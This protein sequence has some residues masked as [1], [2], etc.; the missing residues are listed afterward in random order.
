MTSCGPARRQRAA[1][2]EV[3]QEHRR[4]QVARAGGADRQPGV[5]VRQAPSADTTTMSSGSSG[6]S[7]R[8]TLVTS[9][10]DGPP[11]RTGSAAS[12]SPPATVDRAREEVE[13]EVVGRDHV[14]GRHHPVAH[15]L[16]DPGPDEHAPAHVPHHRVAAVHRLGVVPLTGDRVEDDRPDVLRAL[17]AREHG[18]APVERP[19]VLDARRSPRR[20]LGRQQRTAPVAVPGVVGEVHGHHRPHLLAQ[21]LKGKN[22][23]AVAGMAVGDQGLDRQDAH[24]H[25]FTRGCRETVTPHGELAMGSGRT[26]ASL[27]KPAPS[28][29]LER[30]LRQAHPVAVDELVARRTRGRR[31]RRG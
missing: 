20:C 2:E 26:P 10:T 31:P 19:A 21:P 13:L 18:L 29:H 8:T 24:G 22:G 16:G 5:R 14:G 27:G 1:V 4:G 17:V 3:R 15:E 30:A 12:S 6:V 9:T 23:G 7:S 28:G 11:V 25:R